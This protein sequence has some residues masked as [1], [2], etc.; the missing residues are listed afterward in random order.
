MKKENIV[1]FVIYFYQQSF[2][3]T[4][5]N[6]ISKRLTDS[7]E[8]YEILLIKTVGSLSGEEEKLLESIPF[9]RI[10]YMAQINSL[11]E[12]HAAGILSAIGDYVILSDGNIEF[13]APFLALQESEAGGLDLITGV[14]KKQRGLFYRVLRKVFF[15]FF[16]VFVYSP[17]IKNATN[18]KIISRSLVQAVT[19]KDVNVEKLFL[20]IANTSI[21]QTTFE[22]RLLKP[23]PLSLASGFR[24]SLNLVVNSSTKPLKMV[25]LL[26]IF[27]S[28]IG[29]LISAFAL[30]VHIYK[31][32]HIEGWTSLTLFSSVQFCLIFVILFFLSEYLARSIDQNQN[33]IKDT[34][35]F[36]RVS[37][38]LQGEDRFNIHTEEVN[39]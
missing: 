34:I 36:E 29:I 1:S 2:N 30:S 6:E 21:R 38:V 18:L 35:V 7:Y 25:S 33:R 16:G 32:N 22:H 39:I 15:M 19:K 20:D 27:G 9:L 12:A 28:L 26:G 37:T 23:T 11:E 10:I 17:K 4:Y 31:D 24:R 8:D 14:S 3:S 5:L 13:D